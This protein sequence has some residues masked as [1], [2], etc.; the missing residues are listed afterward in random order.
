MFGRCRPPQ[1]WTD[2]SLDQPPG[3]LHL[4]GTRHL[5]RF[6]WAGNCLQMTPGQVQVD[7]GVGELGMPSRT[8]I[9]RRSAPAS[10][11]WVAKL[12]LSLWGATCFAMP[13]C[14]AASDTNSVR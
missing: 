1:G 7:R 6:Q 3:T 13:A 2:S 10:S 11:M 14:F 8:W 9:V 12:C 4:V 5:D